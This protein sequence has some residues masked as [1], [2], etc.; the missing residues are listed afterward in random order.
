ML[1][2]GIAHK[3]L[4]FLRTD[5]DR[6]E[7]VFQILSDRFPSAGATP[8]SSDASAARLAALSPVSLLS[9][10]VTLSLLSLP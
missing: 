5:A 9:G 3:V 6:D 4:N 1:S 10:I 8:S 7:D 2:P